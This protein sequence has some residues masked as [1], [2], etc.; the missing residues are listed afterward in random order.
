MPLKYRH[1]DH[2]FYKDC[3]TSIYKH[4]HWIKDEANFIPWI[5][6]I[7]KFPIIGIDLENTE[8]RRKKEVIYSVSRLSNFIQSNYKEHDQQPNNLLEYPSQLESRHRG[9]QIQTYKKETHLTYLFNAESNTHPHAHLCGACKI[10]GWA[11]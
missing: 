2:F 8:T 7:A 5:A 11:K 3:Y 10:V 1:Y 6:L 9:R 4:Q